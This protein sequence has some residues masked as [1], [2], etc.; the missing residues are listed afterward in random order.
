MANE[1]TERVL[2][3]KIQLRN[4]AAENW[5]AANPILLKGEVGIELDTRKIMVGDG[6][7]D[8]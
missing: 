1:T 2:E 8:W 3:S 7:W 6:T 4:D 5:A